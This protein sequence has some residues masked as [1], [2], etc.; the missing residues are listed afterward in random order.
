MHIPKV[1]EISM[2]GKLW[3]A[4]GR[5]VVTE[6]YYLLFYLLVSLKNARVKK[7]LYTKLHRVEPAVDLQ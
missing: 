7:R 6:R 2:Q 5:N 1:L 3:I 4:Q